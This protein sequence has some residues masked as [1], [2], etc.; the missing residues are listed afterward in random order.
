MKRKRKASFK[1]L[2]V[3]L[4]CGGT[5]SQLGGC[6]A[7]GFNNMLAAIDF[8]SVLGPDCVLG[9][10][11]PCGDPDTPLDDLL[12]DCPGNEGFGGIGGGDDQGGGGTGGT[13]T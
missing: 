4:L 1:L 2:T 5:L 7:A 11:A 9:P 10:I 13:G 12:T 8:C 6:F 3:V